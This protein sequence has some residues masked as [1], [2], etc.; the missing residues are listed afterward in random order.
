MPKQKLCDW[1]RD[2][3]DCCRCPASWEDIMDNENGREYDAG[4]FIKGSDWDEKPC[5]IPWI[6]R[7][8]L[9]RRG[10]YFENHQYDGYGD[11]YLKDLDGTE[12]IKNSLIKNMGGVICWEDSDGNFHKYDQ[13]NHIDF[14]LYRVKSDY[15]DFLREPRK[16]LP[17]KWKELIVET[18]SIP[19]DYIK[20]YILK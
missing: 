8:F 3:H 1:I 14:F 20:S 2:G 19:I 11:S 16:S 7:W 18:I 5:R 6:I 15:D 9:C 17:K 4:C 13:V 12:I 10:K